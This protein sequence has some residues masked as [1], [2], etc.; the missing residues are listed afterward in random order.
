MRPPPTRQP[1]ATSLNPF[2]KLLLQVFAG[3]PKGRPMLLGLRSKERNGIKL[4]ADIEGATK[5]L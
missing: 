2:E 3:T 4:V 5:N 1:F